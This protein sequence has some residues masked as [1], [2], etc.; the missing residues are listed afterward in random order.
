VAIACCYEKPEVSFP[1]V[2]GNTLP[3]E[4]KQ[5]QIEGEF[6]KT[7]IIFIAKA[8]IRSF[9]MILWNAL[10]PKIAFT[11]FTLCHKIYA[12]VVTFL[13][14]SSFIHVFSLILM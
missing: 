14:F 12:S 9:F 11:F 3:P 8:P 7:R 13:M 5:A 10:G 2:M 6:Q 4:V 1:I